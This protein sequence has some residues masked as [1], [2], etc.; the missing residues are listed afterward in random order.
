MSTA[1][2]LIDDVRSR[3][4]EATAD[5]NSDTEI[6]RWLNQ[7][8]RNFIAKTEY[9]EKIK[10]YRVIANQYE[11]DVPSDMMSIN[12]IRWQDKWDVTWRDLAEFNNYTGMSDSTGDRPVHYRLYP[13][14]SKFR[15]YPIPNASSASTTM[16]DTSGINTTDTSVVLLSSTS[17]P[18]R[19]RILI[20]SEQLLYYANASSTL[21]QLVRGDGG[22]TAASHADL[23]AVYYA[24]MEVYYS[25]M[26]PAMVVSS[27]DCQLPVEYDE[28][29]IAYACEIVFRAKDKYEIASKYKTTY[30]E[31][32]ELGLK[33]VAER[34]RDRLPCIKDESYDNI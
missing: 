13:S 2:S 14:T 33:A 11:Y 22:T 24:P 30:N 6:L 12:Q 20:E 9:L 25:Y 21:S 26:P 19:G 23:T 27:V 1:Q 8:Y 28:A 7:G 18:S 16:N 29:L 5:F 32:V 17:F 4:I 15:V 34:Q 3:I 10:A 31:F